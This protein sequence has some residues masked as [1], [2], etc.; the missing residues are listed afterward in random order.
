MGGGVGLSAHGSHS[1]VT[2]KYLFAMPGN[3][4]RS[5]SRCRRRLLPDAPSGC[6]RHLPGAHQLPP[7]GGGRG[8]GG[9]RACLRAECQ[10]R[11]AAGGSRRGRSLRPARQREGRCRDRQVPGGCRRP[12]AA[13]ADA[14]D[15]SLLLGRDA[16]GDRGG[17]EEIETASSPRSSLAAL[18]K[19]SPLSMAIT[20]AQLKACANK[21]FEDTMTIEYADVAALHAEGPRFLRRRARAADR[22]G[23]EAAMEPADDR[24]R[25][26]SDG[27]GAFQAGVETTCSSD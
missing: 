6:A 10:D 22:Q 4:H 24:R 25:D 20:L 13:G 18:L 14:G 26:R 21:S 11:R 19:L 23:P 3:D 5:L 2:E 17:V 12:D 9:Y 15:R 27:R 16:A 1:V 7:Q 8:V